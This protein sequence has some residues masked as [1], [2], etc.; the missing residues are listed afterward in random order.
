MKELLNSIFMRK[1]VRKY[2][3]E[4]LSLDQLADIEGYLGEVKPLIPSISTQFEI[5]PC[6]DTN[7]KFNAEYC[8]LCYSEK[9]DLWLTNVGYM[10]EQ[11][12][13]YLASIGVGV[14]WYGMGKVEEDQKDGLTYAIMLSFGKCD[15]DFR[16]DTS[17]FKRNKVSDFWKNISDK[18]LGEIVRLAP[19]AVNSQPWCVEQNGNELH[20]YREKGN[21]PILSGVLFK[22][23]NKVD[24]GIF[25]CYLEIALESVG[26]T[27]NRELHPETDDKKRVLVATY[28]LSK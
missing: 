20:V 2:S 16:K 21:T 8:L 14:C 18:K 15:D 10:L 25:M 23:W 26:Y 19:S 4:K 5:V 12:E 3:E 22:H 27:F 7:C 6:S 9:K 17:E 11:W 28:T 24:I 1:S 13:L